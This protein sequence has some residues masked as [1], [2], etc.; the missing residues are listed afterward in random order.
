MESSAEAATT[1]PQQIR[2]RDL[3]RIGG[4]RRIGWSWL[5]VSVRRALVCAPLLPEYDRESGS[6]RTFHLIE[7]LR[8]AGFAVSFIAQN[9]AAGEQR[10]VRALQQRGVA[11]YLGFNSQTD[12]LIAAGR[13]DLAVFAFWYLA[14]P[15]MPAIRRLS[16]STR[17]IVDSID[18]HFLRDARRIFHEAAQHR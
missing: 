2:F 14:E 6:R 7:F 5:P 15:Y 8:D 13:F 4:A 1:E 12:R 11:T 10:Y 16:P 3:V 9:P 18:L 17:V